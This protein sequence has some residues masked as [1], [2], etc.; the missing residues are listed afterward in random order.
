MWG[1]GCIRTI[2]ATLVLFTA[3]Q[4]VAQSHLDE[5]QSICVEADGDRDLAIFLAERQGWKPI[6]T[7]LLE[8]L[9]QNIQLENASG[10]FRV[11]GSGENI[12]L[13]AGTAPDP[14]TSLVTNACNLLVSEESPN[15]REAVQNW[16][17]VPP[18]RQTDLMTSWQFEVVDG[19]RVLQSPNDVDGTY[20]W[21]LLLSGEGVTRYEYS[22]INP[23]KAHDG[24]VAAPASSTALRVQSFDKFERI[25]LATGGETGRVRTLLGQLGWTRIDRTSGISDGSQITFMSDPAEGDSP[26]DI[27]LFGTLQTPGD[28]EMSNCS[29]AGQATLDVLQAHMTEWAG[30]EPRRNAQGVWIWAY[31]QDSAQITPQHDLVDAGDIQVKAAARTRGIIHLVQVR[32]SPAGQPFIQ[33]S[34]VTP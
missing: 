18:I 2:V 11:G 24:Q 16:I 32:N 22:K 26:Q 25:C 5:L 3:G 31:T 4:A 8:S 15:A 29:V 9:S 12:F 34:I 33:H 23:G 27:V 10:R 7:A 6:P 28:V 19:R 14:D 21:T 1:A 30:F 17:G 13:L 20:Y